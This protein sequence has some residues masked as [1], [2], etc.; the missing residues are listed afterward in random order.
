MWNSRVFSIVYKFL[1]VRYMAPEIFTAK[2]YTEKVDIF[3][4]GILLFTLIN[5]TPP[6]KGKD[7]KALIKSTC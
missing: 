6:F 3:S 7:L 4:L 1:L 5:G 2:G